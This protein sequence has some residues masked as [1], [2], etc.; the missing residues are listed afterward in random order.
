MTA[1][2]G[3]LQ[4]RCDY[5][6]WAAVVMQPASRYGFT[7]GPPRPDARPET[8]RH[9]RDTPV[10]AVGSPQGLS[11]ASVLV[12]AEPATRPAYGDT[13]NR[14]PAGSTEASTHTSRA[15]RSRAWISASPMVEGVVLLEGANVTSPDLT[16]IFPLWNASEH[17]Q[18][19]IDFVDSLTWLGTETILV[20]DCSDDG[21]SQAID[22]LA[23]SRPSTIAVHT[24][25][26]GGAGAAR[27]AGFVLAT[28]R[29]TVFLD[30][31]DRFDPTALKQ[32]IDALEE[33][34]ADVAMTP[35]NFT[36]ST[37]GQATGM[38]AKDVLIWDA[39]LRGA[40]Q[41]VVHLRENSRLLEFTNYPWNKVIRT[42]TFAT[43]GLRFGET[44]VHND[45]LGHWQTLLHA[46][47]IVLVNRPVV[48]HVVRPGATNLSNRQGRQRQALVEA[49]EELL[50]FL[51]T[52]E[53]DRTS[54]G[55]PYWAF[56]ARTSRWAHGQ[57]APEYRADL[58]IG[59]S[60]LFS[61][62]SVSEYARMRMSRSAAIVDFVADVAL[63]Q[64]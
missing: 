42:E 58:R 27:N 10:N 37:G 21:S 38:H 17:I 59:L 49:L 46:D 56:A 62:M 45:I 54:Y 23:R 7:S 52:S 39:I 5:R 28:G 44:L 53:A 22:E 55:V 30:I 33:T 8:A 31:D 18:S 57:I 41:R 50:R 20:D 63:N 14:P 61:K 11:A 51:D 43:R 15:R 13:L 34:G 19:A 4:R 29:Y 36:R 26:R 12:G 16:L 64:E 24:E 3:R 47:E 60:R 1:P 2:V 25:A 9:F 6:S 40:S 48:T 35:Y 32:S